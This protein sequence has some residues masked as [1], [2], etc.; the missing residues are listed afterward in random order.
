MQFSFEQD[1]DHYIVIEPNSDEGVAFVEIDPEKKEITG[2]NPVHRIYQ[3]Y[4][5]EVATLTS[6][7]PGLSEVSFIQAP[8]A[9]FCPFADFRPGVIVVLSQT[10]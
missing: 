9:C 1:G 8:T 7:F 4:G 5:K 3:G 10:P 6:I 2:Y